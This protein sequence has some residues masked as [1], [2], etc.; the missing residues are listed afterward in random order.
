MKVNE[1]PVL[2]GVKFGYIALQWI[3]DNLFSCLENKVSVSAGKIL[4]FLI[5]AFLLYCRV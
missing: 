2:K 4:L 3:L 1:A 5:P